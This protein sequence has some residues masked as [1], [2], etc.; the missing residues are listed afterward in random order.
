MLEMAF[1]GFRC[2][3]RISLEPE[4]FREFFPFLFIQIPIYRA[5]FVGQK[6]GQIFVDLPFT[7]SDSAQKPIEQLA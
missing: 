6:R 1:I 2:Q 7:L 5:V 3:I 4:S